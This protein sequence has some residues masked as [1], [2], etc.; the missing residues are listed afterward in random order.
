[1]D[2]MGP[3]PYYIFSLAGIDIAISFFM[4]LPFRKN[5]KSKY[6]SWRSY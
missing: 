4:Y 5:K 6:G 3:W 2:F 1:M